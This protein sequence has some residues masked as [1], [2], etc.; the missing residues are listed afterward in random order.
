MRVV[1]SRKHLSISEKLAKEL[2]GL[3]KNF[4]SESYS[5]IGDIEGVL[6]KRDISV[7]KKKNILLKK[8]HELIV[9][10]F[11]IDRKKFGNKSFESLKKRMHGTRKV[12][13]KLRSINYYLETTFLEDLNLSKRMTGEKK[14][15]PKHELE[16]NELNAL[17]YAAYRLISKA[18]MLDKRLLKEYAQKSESAATKEKEETQDLRVLLRKE[19]L[20][21]EHLEA[22]I[23][24]PKAVS[25]RLLAEPMFTHWTARLLSLL[26]YLEYLH[27]IEAIIFARLKQNK[28]A[29]QMISKKISGLMK[30]KS[31]LIRIMEEKEISMKKFSFDGKLKKEL[32][33][34][35]TT[36]T[37]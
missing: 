26:S 10:T 28:E 5:K 23:P 37:L 17:E 14:S 24:P 35:T 12:I 27:G 29:R 33:Q 6:L 31:K 9:S 1:I 30:E 16:K 11:S 13:N 21:L 32:H 4:N 36:I 18:V 8:L 19:S 7:E 22:K 20:L 2:N 3:V 15:K 34:L 25:M